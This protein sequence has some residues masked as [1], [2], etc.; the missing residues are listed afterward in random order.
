M[1]TRKPGQWWDRSWNLQPRWLKRLRLFGEIVWRPHYD[2]RMSAALAWD[3]AC[4][5]DPRR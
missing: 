5:M 1:T 4:A 2:G 3:V